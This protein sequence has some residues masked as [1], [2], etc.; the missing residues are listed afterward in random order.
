[1][2]LSRGSDGGNA[3][4]KLHP[5]APSGLV[6]PP[7]RGPCISA[8][9]TQGSPGRTGVRTPLPLGPAGSLSQQPLRGY[10]GVAKRNARGPTRGLRAAETTTRR[11]PR[12]RQPAHPPQHRRGAISCHS[13]GFRRL[14]RARSSGPC[15]ALWDL[16]SR[17]GPSRDPAGGREGCDQLPRHGAVLF[18]PHSPAVPSE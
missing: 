7:E 14:P 10:L 18:P 3:E 2:G 6:L 15:P 4:V 11:P 8:G 1:M 9:G 16:S 5:K 13:P 12:R 17:R